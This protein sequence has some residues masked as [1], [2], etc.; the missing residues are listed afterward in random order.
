MLSFVGRF[1]LAKTIER[2]PAA[3]R[4]EEGTKLETSVPSTTPP[5]SSHLLMSTT[6]PWLKLIWAPLNEKQSL[7]AK[8]SKQSGPVCK[9]H[10]LQYG[11]VF[12]GESSPKQGDGFRTCRTM[13]GHTY[14]VLAHTSVAQYQKK[15]M[16]CNDNVNG[17]HQ[18]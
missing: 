12:R 11:C 10:Y 3:R 17:K 15:T 7:N 4:M 9:D 18:L 2:N 14:S 6:L 16:P 5:S 1:A 13:R 8:S